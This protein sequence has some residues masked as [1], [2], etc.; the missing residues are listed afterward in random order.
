[1]QVTAIAPKCRV[2][3][4]RLHSATRYFAVYHSTRRPTTNGYIWSGDGD[5]R[6]VVHEN[7]VRLLRPDL[8][9]PRPGRCIEVP[10]LTNHLT[11][12][13]FD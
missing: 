2:F 11:A 4:A 13:L 5:A 12:T 6:E 9:L 1:M 10:E 3:L 8:V 7:I